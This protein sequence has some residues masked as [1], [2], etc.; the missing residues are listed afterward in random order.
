MVGEV[1][2]VLFEGESKESELL[3]QGRMETQAPD[4]DGCVLIN[5]VP[6]GVAAGAGRICERRDHGSAGVRSDRKNLQIDACHVKES[7]DELNPAVVVPPSAV[8]STKTH[9]ERSRLSRA[10]D[11]DVRSRLFAVDAG[12]VRI[13]GWRRDLLVAYSDSYRQ[14]AGCACRCFDRSSHVRGIWAASRTEESGRSKRSGQS[15]G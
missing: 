1:V 9:T 4:I 13:A 6:E 7:S 12:N 3:W 14:L 11:R 15:G 5:D 8:P 10:R 2:R